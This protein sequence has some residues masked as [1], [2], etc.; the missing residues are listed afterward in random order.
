ML[1]SS[2]RVSF[3][4]WSKK[5]SLNLGREQKAHSLPI[6]VMVFQ[7]IFKDLL[8]HNYASYVKPLIARSTQNGIL[9]A[10]DGLLTFAAGLPYPSPER[11]R[12]GMDIT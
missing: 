11:A 3:L 1:F 4:V 6:K 7:I 2:V 5:E 9:V 12:V 10:S 8:A